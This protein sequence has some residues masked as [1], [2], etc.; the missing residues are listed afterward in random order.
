MPNTSF[1]ILSVELVNP[2]YAVTQVENARENCAMLN[3]M[4]E[5]WTNRLHHMRVPWCW[6]TRWSMRFADPTCWLSLS[7]D[8]GTNWSV[9]RLHILPLETLKNY[10]K[11]NKLRICS[12]S[13]RDG[14]ARMT[15]GWSCSDLAWVR[16]MW[17]LTAAPV[18]AWLWG[19]VL[20]LTYSFAAWKSTAEW[21]RQQLC[22]E[23]CESGS[24]HTAEWRSVILLNGG[25][26]NACMLIR[27]L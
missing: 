27:N 4:G 21:W 7:S 16:C 2:I 13:F 5:V 14:T 20:R 1:G 10:Y 19:Q 9:E 8:D 3:R 11:K 22:S 24:S 6:Q 17:R 15:G 23:N 18:P 26:S 12:H 25:L